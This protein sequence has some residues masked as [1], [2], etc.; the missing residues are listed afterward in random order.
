MALATA[1][2][3]YVN[4]HAVDGQGKRPFDDAQL[5]DFAFGPFA[6]ASLANGTYSLMALPY[7]CD[8]EA[9]TIYQNVK[10]T[11]G[12]ITFYVAPSGTA[13]GSGTAISGANTW[14]SGTAATVQAIDITS[15]GTANK[16]LAAGTQFGFVTANTILTAAGVSFVVTLRRRPYRTTDAGF[17]MYNN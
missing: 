12:D 2:G 9:I 10:G 6:A 8:I 3:T 14:T 7:D 17:K 16:N 1:P 13:L 11:Q 5:E 15:T 4:P